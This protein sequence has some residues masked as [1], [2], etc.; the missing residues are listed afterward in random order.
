[1]ILSF[2][3]PIRGK[4]LGIHTLRSLLHLP[5]DKQ[6]NWIKESSH[7]SLHLRP[8]PIPI[9]FPLIAEETICPFIL[10]LALLENLT[11][12]GAI[13]VK[14]A[15][16]QNPP[17]RIIPDKYLGRHPLGIQVAKSKVDG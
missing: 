16:L 5:V 12:Q 2:G 9:T 17:A 7:H 3:D 10:P 1:M 14:S 8:I 13:K 15:F 11:P 6:I 4:G